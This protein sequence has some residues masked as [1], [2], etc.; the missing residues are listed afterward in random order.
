M[1]QDGE[2]RDDEVYADLVELVSGAKP[3][4]ESDDEC[5]YF[6]AVGLSFVDVAIAHAMYLQALDRGVGQMLT[7]QDTMIF[8]HDEI[9]EWVRL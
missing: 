2:L 5:A 4:R 7:M 6:N 8:E 3:G 1:Y 9:A